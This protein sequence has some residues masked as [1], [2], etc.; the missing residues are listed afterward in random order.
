MAYRHV[1]SSL[2]FDA[3]VIAKDDTGAVAA[4]FPGIGIVAALAVGGGSVRRST[5]ISPE[6]LAADLHA[7]EAS[8]TATE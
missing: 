3:T 1:G 4:L 8:A 2:D 6:R 5:D 7:A